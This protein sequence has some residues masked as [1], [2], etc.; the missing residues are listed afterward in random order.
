VR[1]IGSDGSMI[2]IVKIREA[3]VAAE[4]AGLDLVEIA[5]LAKPPVCKIIDFGKYRYEQSKK[6]KDARKKQHVVQ[7]KRIQLKHNI[8]DHDFMIKVNAA[9]RFIE[10][11]H[12]VKAIM[13]I[14][15]RLVTRKEI[16]EK[17]L[18]RMTEELADIAKTDGGTKQEGAHNLSL[19]LVK[20]K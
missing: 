12:R 10:E 11:G 4:E 2:G 15:G 14:R 6:L 18:I 13:V 17:I 5:P 9:R 3:L 16:A 8:D 7:L 20:K 1:L 19:L